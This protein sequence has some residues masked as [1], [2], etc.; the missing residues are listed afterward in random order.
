MDN[1]LLLAAEEAQDNLVDFRGIL[2]NT[3]QDEVSPAPFHYEWSE[4]LLNGKENYA[5]EGFRESAKGQIVLRAF[6]LY[7]LAYPSATR[8]YIVLIKQNDRLAQNKLLEIEEEYL[9]NPALSANLVTVKHKSGKI[10]EVDVKDFNGD[11]I[12]I[13]IEAYG[14]GSSIR[15][16]DNQNRR[17]R[18]VV[19]DD[20]QD[21][22][23]SMSDT[24]LIQDWQWFLDDVCFLGQHSRIF[25]IGNNLGDKCIIERVHKNPAELKF[26]IKKIAILDKDGN[27]AW[28]D[29]FPLAEIEDERE[30]F[31]RL[32]QLDVWIRE[33]MCEAISQESRIVTQ[34]DLGLRYSTV[35]ID[36]LLADAAIYITMDP[37][38]S[39]NK[40]ACYRAFCVNA[41]KRDVHGAVQWFILDFPYGRWASDK[42]LDILFQLV[43]TWKPT[44]VGIE[45]G[46]YEQIMMPFIRQRM[47]RDNI[48]FTVTPLEHM[49]RGSKLERV[50]M[51]GPRFKAKGIWL[52][53]SAPWLAEFEAEMLGVTIDGFKSLFTDLADTLAMQ[54]Q[55]ARPPINAAKDAMQRTQNSSQPLQRKDYD[56]ISGKRTGI[57]HQYPGRNSY[58]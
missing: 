26:Q 2:L 24:V 28:P 9:T 22:E 35:Y 31:R 14:K 47:L 3:G 45:K 32:G 39:E 44:A 29:K 43:V 51:L 25:L 13:R 58:Q 36:K 38:S 8:D 56:P 23:D 34:D 48:T 5:I 19:I 55:L 30:R 18:I 15:G 21:L 54:D 33:R 52:P 20:P 53:E 12:N 11:I 40:N 57:Q 10:F 7:A 50:K 27:S 17:P 46:M 4:I 49:K 16:L 41:V 42:S 1:E 6:L 37:A